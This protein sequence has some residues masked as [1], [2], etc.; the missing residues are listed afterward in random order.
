MFATNTL[1]LDLLR[2]VLGKSGTMSIPEHI[3]WDELF[4]SSCQQG[5][6]L[7]V[8]DGIQQTDIS[9]DDT[10]RYKWVGLTGYHE[11]RY[12]RYT[13]SIARLADFYRSQGLAMMVLKGYGLS[14]NYPISAHRPMGDLD[15]YL[16]SLDGRPAHKNLYKMGDKA[17]TET[18]GIKVDDSHHHHSV[19][20]FENIT[21]ENHYD[22]INVYSRRSNRVAEHYLKE[23]VRETPIVH[24]LYS[25]PLLLPP[26]TF[27][28]LFL[29]RHSAGHFAAINMPLRHILDWMLFVERHGDTIDWKR[30]MPVL[31]QLNLKTF[32]SI[33]NTIGVRYL[34]FDAS[35]FPL[36]SDDDA[37][38]QRVLEEILNPGFSESETGTL[39]SALWVKPR[40]WWHNRWKNRLCYPDSLTS[41]FFHS[42][43]AKILKPDHFRRII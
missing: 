4:H 21:V 7:L 35:L 36:M 42:L 27:N 39:S 18:F 37:L 3:D 24:E 15:I 19:F 2:V 8:Y 16:T 43:H 12:A 30:L 14:L 10:T 26:D 5:V 38:V 6:A 32:C 17:L 11:A 40:R 31:E 20:Q 23:W 13:T 28:A 1:L 41:T 22:F 25:V 9:M 29:L 33:I 34:G